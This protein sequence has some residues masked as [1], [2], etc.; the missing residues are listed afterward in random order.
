M[1]IPSDNMHDTFNT[2]LLRSVVKI[3][4][5]MLVLVFGLIGGAGLFA[6]TYLSLLRGLPNPGHY[7]NLLGVF[8]PGYQVSHA[9]AWVGLFWGALVGGLLA[10]FIYR[11]YART[12]PER[13]REL[14]QQGDSGDNI[15]GLTLRFDGHALG[16]ALAAVVAAGLVVTTNLLV[17][18]GTAA[19]SV[20]AILLVNYLPGYGISLSGSLIG[21]A[22]L[23]IITY[24]LSRF[25]SWI[26]NTTVSYRSKSSG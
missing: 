20:H 5:I 19:E 12:I 24:V 9:G 11:I 16:L 21:A 13:A 6:A 26:Y 7:L 15:L 14:M 25:F 2:A 8:L 10:A 17:L 18:R 3:N 1:T 22:Q 4:T 23:F